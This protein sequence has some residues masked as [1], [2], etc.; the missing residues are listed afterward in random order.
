VLQC[1]LV[2]YSVLQRVCG[3]LGLELLNINFNVSVYEREEGG[4]G[5]G[6]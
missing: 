6:G 2:Y 4:G 1:I 5:R 3:S